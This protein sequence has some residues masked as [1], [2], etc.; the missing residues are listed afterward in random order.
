TL[1]KETGG[2]PEI[3]PLNAYYTNDYLQ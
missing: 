3:K 1:L 2:L